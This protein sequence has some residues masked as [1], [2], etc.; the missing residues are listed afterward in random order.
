MTSCTEKKDTPDSDQKP[1]IIDII[2]DDQGWTDYSLMGHEHIETP[3]IDRLAGE[4]L[5]FVWGY[6]AAPLCRPAKI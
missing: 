6:S 5:T 4:G 1:N 3:N 2:S